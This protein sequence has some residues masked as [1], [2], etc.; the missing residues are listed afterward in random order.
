VVQSL[1]LPL[2]AREEKIWRHDVPSHPKAYEY[3]LR[4]N[5]F[6]RE[7]QQWSEAR[8]LDLKCLEADPAFAPAWAR[9]GRTHHVMAK[10]LG[11]SGKDE[12]DRAEVAFKKAL[13][14]NVELGVAHKAYAQL[15]VDCGRARDAMVRLLY[16]ARGSSDSEMFAGLFSPLRY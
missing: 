6:S 2:S 3:F 10:Y 4:A 5:Q 14:L 7:P 12:F 13:D 11:A 8:E 16:R 15:E 1:S 9:L